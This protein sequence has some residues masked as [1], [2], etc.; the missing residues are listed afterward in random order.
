MKKIFYIHLGLVLSVTLLFSC[1]KDHEPQTQLVVLGKISGKIVAA[2]NSSAIKVATV[3]T[4]DGGQLYITH[5]DET[6]SFLLEAPA[7]SRHVTIQTGDGSIFRTEID[8]VVVENQTT[9][10]INAPVVLNQVA[11]LA[12]IPGTYDKIEDILV[13]SM[14]Y[15]ATAI[16][17]NLLDTMANFTCYDAIFINCTS[18]SL[19]PLVSTTTDNN[20]ANYV[21]NG[22][23][24]Y[25]SDH[26]VKYLVG[27]ELTPTTPC[28]VDRVGGFIPDNLLCVRKT[29]VVGSVINAPITSAPLQAYLNKT[30]IDEIIYNLNAWEK[31]NTLDSNF[32]ETMVTDLS[33]NPLLIRTNSFTNPGGGTY[34]VGSV[35]NT[36]YSLI[37]TPVAGGT[38][39]TLSVKSENVAAYIA[40]GAVAGMCDNTTSAGRIYYTTFHN[41]PNGHIG[42]DIRNILE[43]VILNL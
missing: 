30:T 3:F 29:G 21:A 26:A 41:E 39:V 36:G 28:S 32:W 37:C 7:G 31:I 11:T 19:T 33:G 4:N 20:L 1:K 42:A 24:L 34:P 6:G 40:N 14:G 2:N 43:Y 27:Q 17:W 25:I 23:S 13:D 35:L 18:I 16:T 22:G 15:T 5:S 8:V 10:I 38:N 12:Y 9:Q